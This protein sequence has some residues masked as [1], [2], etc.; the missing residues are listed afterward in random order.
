MPTHRYPTR[1]TN[2][3]NLIGVIDDTNFQYFIPEKVPG[4]AD[5]SA[6]QFAGAIINNDNEEDLEYQ[7]LLTKE[8]YREVWT[9]YFSK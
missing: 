8:K 2:S 1:S 9:N 5:E 4:N 6:P 7:H 3:S